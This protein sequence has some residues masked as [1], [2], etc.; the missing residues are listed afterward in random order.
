MKSYQIS[1]GMMWH[2][3]HTV[4]VLCFSL[5]HHI[6]QMKEHFKTTYVNSP[7]LITNCMDHSLSWEANSS[8]PS[9]DILQTSWNCRTHYHF[10]YCQPEPTSLQLLSHLWLGLPSGSKKDFIYGLTSSY[11]SFSSYIIHYK[12]KQPLHEPF[13]QFLRIQEPDP[14]TWCTHYTAHLACVWQLM[15]AVKRYP[16]FGNHCWLGDFI[17]SLQGYKIYIQIN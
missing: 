8:S 5:H 7:L 6:Q 10:L 16:R 15:T 17:K 4:P 13:W 3:F 12:K 11:T 9:R 1:P 2:S 14:K